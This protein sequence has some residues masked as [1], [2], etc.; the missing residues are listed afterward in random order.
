MT[1]MD[2]GEVEDNGLFANEDQIKQV[3]LS[4]NNKDEDDDN[5]QEVDSDVEELFMDAMDEIQ[6]ASV[7]YNRSQSTTKIEENKEAN[8]IDSSTNNDGEEQQV[9]LNQENS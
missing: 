4:Y 6:S 8:Q 7:R 3:T 2:K 5:E 1:E 9:I